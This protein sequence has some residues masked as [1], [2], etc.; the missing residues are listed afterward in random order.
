MRIISGRFKGR[1]IAVP[2]NF[3]G[4]PTTDFAREGL[5]N[6]LSHLIDLDGASVLDLF[7][8]TGA[9]GIEC[10][11][12][13]A[14]HLTSVEI[15]GLHVKAISENFKTFDFQDA[16]V[17]KLD[18][19]RYIQQ[20][21]KKFDLIFADPPYDLVELQQLPDLLL[22]SGLLNE[23][24]LLVIEHGKRTDFSAY[25]HF[26]QTRVYSNVHFSFFRG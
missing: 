15:Q 26:L 18:V 13:G 1:Q 20:G 19:F 21:T 3:K 23:N 2:R 6:V 16:L 14:A 8:G 10:V 22:A 7:A 11:S 12:R 4:R 9:F 25:K 24:G 5:F 17:L